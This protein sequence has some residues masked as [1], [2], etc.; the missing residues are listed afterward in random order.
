MHDSLALLLLRRINLIQ[1]LVELVL[2]VHGLAEFRL[3]AVLAAKH[4]RVRKCA[5]HVL[6]VLQHRQVEDG[7]AVLGLDDRIDIDD[8]RLISRLADDFDV[9]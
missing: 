4:E 9:R 7:D 6:I 3:L 5:G 1:I 8:R 2:I